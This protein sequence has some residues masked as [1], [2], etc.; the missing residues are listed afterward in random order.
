VISWKRTIPYASDVD[1]AG[2]LDG[3][4]ERVCS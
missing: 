2:D 4:I 1:D 3:G